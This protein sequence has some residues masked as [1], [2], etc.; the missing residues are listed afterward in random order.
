[1]KKRVIRIAEEF[2]ETNWKSIKSRADSILGLGNY[3]IEELRSVAL[4]S[5][6]KFHLDKKMNRKSKADYTTAFLFSLDKQLH[7]QTEVIAFPESKSYHSRVDQEEGMDIEQTDATLDIWAD[8]G[9]KAEHTWMYN[10]PAFEEEIPSNGG[11]HFSISIKSFAKMRLSPPLV[12]SLVLLTTTDD[13]LR[14]VGEF[15]GSA[16]AKQIPKK[17]RSKL[18]NELKARGAKIYKGECLNGKKSHVIVCASSESEAQQYFRPYG[19][20]LKCLEINIESLQ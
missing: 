14:S 13:G 16:R 10:E 19:R 6:Y 9:D 18:G 8:G 7:G 3:N 20:L 11:H 4:L 2:I 17:F 5:Y 15:V 1:M 12:E